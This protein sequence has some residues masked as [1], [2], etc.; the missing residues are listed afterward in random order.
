MK[1]IVILI[2]GRGSNMQAIVQAAKIEQ[3]PAEIVAV[4]SNRNDAAGLEYASSMGIPT[5][6]VVSKNFPTREAFDAVLQATIDSYSPDLVVLAGFMRILSASFVQHYT[7]RIMNIHPSLLPSFVGMAT[8][9]QALDAGVKLHGITVHFVTPELDH[10]PIID[11]VAVK[12][13]ATDTEESLAQRLLIQEH[14]A[15]P[16]AVRWFIEGKL[17]I[18]GNRVD[19]DTD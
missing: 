17:K 18:E 12:V 1:R 9:K 14:I 19:V 11:Q 16:R 2:S 6:V 4:I 13:L 7:N 15:Y 3:W 10:G 5:S 8:H